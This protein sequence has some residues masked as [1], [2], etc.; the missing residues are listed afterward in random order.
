MYD[1]VLLEEKDSYRSISESLILVI[2][3][4]NTVAKITKDKLFVKTLKKFPPQKETK[5][6]SENGV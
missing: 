4:G 5:K 2:L 1:A 3:D 6:S